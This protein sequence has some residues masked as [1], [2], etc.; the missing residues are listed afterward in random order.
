[1]LTGA[2]NAT[3]TNAFPPVAVPIVG[4]PGTVVPV[5]LFVAAGVVALPR[6]TLNNSFAS[7]SASP[8]TGTENVSVVSKGV[9][10]GAAPT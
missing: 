10:A 4:A 9:V 3:D 8:F 5:K 6:P 1:M 7:S 2:V